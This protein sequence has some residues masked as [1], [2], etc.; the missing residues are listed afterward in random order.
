MSAPV[1]NRSRLG[2]VSGAMPALTDPAQTDDVVADYRRRRVLAALFPLFLASGATSLVYETLWERQLHLVFGT[3][4][5]AVY[6]VLAAFMTGLA[7]GGFIAARYVHRAARPLRTYALLE[8]CIGLYAL[9]FP[10]VLALMEPAYLGFFR[11]LSPSPLSFAVFQ[12]FLLGVAL[13]PATTCM[14]A[15]LPLLVRFATAQEADR[16]AGS[17][18]GRLYGANTL[19]AVIGV[20]MAGFVLLPNA[21]LQATTFITAAGNVLLCGAALWLD[22]QVR[23]MPVSAEADASGVVAPLGSLAAIAALA[24]LASLICEVSWFRL[25][26]LVLGGSA[27]AFSIML[28]SFLLGIGLGGLFGGRL[29]DRAWQSGGTRTVLW[30]LVAAQLGVALLTY[31]AMYAFGELPFVFVYLYDAIEPNL[32]WLWPAKLAL[33]LVVMLPP[34]LLMGATFPLLVRAAADHAEGLGSPVGRIYGWNTVGSILGA[35]VGGLIL[36]PGLRVVG[37]LLVAVCL[38][39]TA[40]MLAAQRAAGL[41][42]ARAAAGFAG[43]LAIG[44]LLFWQPPPW[45]PLMMTAGMYKYVSDLDPEERNR[46]DII[47][48]AVTPYELLYYKEG[49]SSVVTVAKSK[50]SGNIWLANN[51]KV[52]ASTSVDMPTQVLV[53]HLPFA[54]MPEPENVMVIGLASGITAGSVVR[55]SPP[56][57]IDII[58]LEPAIVQAAEL[59][60]EHNN[61]PLEDP[62]VTLYANDGRNHTNLVPPGS[63]DLV[64]SEPSN[65]WQTG[66]SNLF[67]REYLELGKSRLTEGGVWAQWVQMYGMDTDDLRSLLGTFTDVY[68]HVLLFSTIEDAD[69]VIIG[70][71]A[72]LAINNDTMRRMFEIDPAVAAD[73]AEIGC[74]EAEDLL[75]RLQMTRDG[76]REFAGDIERNTDDNMRIEFS[77]PLHLHEMTAEANFYALLKKGG[78]R[79]EPPLIPFEAV[80]GVGG[81]MALSEAYARRED[82]LRAA[83]TIKDDAAQPDAHDDVIA[84]YELYQQRLLAELSDSE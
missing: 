82:W 70:S 65:P 37:A 68:A 61:R 72:P 67:T 75:V 42:P 48:F 6:T 27:Y 14:G 24:G 45:E 84:T 50:S 10:L 25:M 23:P 40:A 83:L 58:E 3:S 31:G 11:A 46:A 57:K 12:F 47:D 38:N 59:F 36:L 7:A 1:P 19:G 30:F 39:L 54:F 80:E 43:V 71:D 5:V 44:A 76:L 51:G 49:L 53:A 55:H 35:S 29:S 63:Y 32:G 41:P 4:Q 33:A 79:K 34:A 81:R 9:L 52:D 78:E 60:N 17:A 56:A 73:L 8:G 15:T 74:P 22:R 16:A 20:A 21:G 13:L 2:I 64:V 26:V 28:L 66:V 18:V 77:A 69:L 62:R